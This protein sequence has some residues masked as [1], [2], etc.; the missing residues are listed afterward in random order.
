MHQASISVH[1]LDLAVIWAEHEPE[2]AP[3]G[4]AVVPFFAVAPLLKLDLF[5]GSGH[6]NI[7]DLLG[8]FLPLITLT[9]IVSA[10]SSE[11]K[12]DVL[13]VGMDRKGF[14]KEAGT[15]TSW[16][17]PLGYFQSAV[18]VCFQRYVVKYLD[19]DAAASELATRTVQTF[20]TDWSQGTRTIF[21]CVTAAGCFVLVCANT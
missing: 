14:I 5:F 7:T 9:N 17:L 3:V 10:R 18:Q 20:F 1:D 11:W 19:S 16:W 4:S 13:F 2:G 8:A 6:N 21:V 12:R 15:A